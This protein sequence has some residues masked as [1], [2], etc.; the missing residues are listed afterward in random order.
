MTENSEKQSGTGERGKQT[1]VT[2]RPRERE[3]VESLAEEEGRSL[4]GQI[5]ALVLEGLSR[6]EL[7]PEV[8]MT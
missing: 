7:R 1:F 6:R 8:P 4:S 5:R 2:L 3:I